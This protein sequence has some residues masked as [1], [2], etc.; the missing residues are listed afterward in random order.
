MKDDS[1]E[2]PCPILSCPLSPEHYVLS[3]P[4]LVVA[5]SIA[6]ATS[7]DSVS[8]EAIFALELQDLRA[9]LYVHKHFSA[10]A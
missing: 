7:C 6:S 4:L 2:I 9:Y 8:S 10:M 5:P 3:D 1:S